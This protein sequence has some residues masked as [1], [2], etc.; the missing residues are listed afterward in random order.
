MTGAFSSLYLCACFNAL[1]WENEILRMGIVGSLASI[2]CDT[3]FH[4][5]DTLNIRAKASTSEIAKGYAAK[6]TLGLMMDIWGKEGFV[7]FSKGFTACCYSAA[8]CGFIYFSLYKTLKPV[9]REHM[10]ESQDRAFCYLLASLLTGAITVSV[11]YPY[12]LIKC[13]F[14]SVNDV[15]KYKNLP[16]AFGSSIK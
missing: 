15:F 7:G 8:F 3:S 5:V 10:G 16:H 1:S 13:R 2:V 9:L 12:D 4:F 11:G 14:Q 6:S